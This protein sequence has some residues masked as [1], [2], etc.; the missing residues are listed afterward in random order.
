MI[1]GGVYT[2]IGPRD[3]FK[4]SPRAKRGVS[5]LCEHGPNAIG[6]G[7]TAVLTRRD[8]WA[9]NLD[10]SV[11]EFILSCAE[12][13]LR[14]DTAFYRQKTFYSQVDNGSSKT[15]LVIAHV[16]NKSDRCR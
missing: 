4:M 10:S 2:G 7:L 6:D 16:I 5:S 13:L 15:V 8:I 11:A 14:N 1:W 3:N 12:G 9:Q